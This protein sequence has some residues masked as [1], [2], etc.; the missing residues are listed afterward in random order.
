MMRTSNLIYYIKVCILLYVSTMFYS[1]V[2]HKAKVISSVHLLNEGLK[3]TVYE[4]E[5]MLKD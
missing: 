1:L 2:G 3:G 4:V 5:S